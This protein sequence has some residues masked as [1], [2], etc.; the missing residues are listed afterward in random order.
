MWYVH[1]VGTGC[2]YVPYCFVSNT[3]SAGSKMLQRV[4]TSTIRAVHLWHKPALTSISTFNFHRSPQVTSGHT[5]HCMY[6]PVI[7]LPSPNHASYNGAY[8]WHKAITSEVTTDHAKLCLCYHLQTICLWLISF[9]PA[10]RQH[11]F[12]GRLHER[13]VV[14]ST[15]GSNIHAIAVGWNTTPTHG[16]TLALSI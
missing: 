15:S 8:K 11:G 2:I 12:H 3:K 13:T 6:L 14:N 16:L 7:D 1:I 4:T 10:R 5:D 9:N